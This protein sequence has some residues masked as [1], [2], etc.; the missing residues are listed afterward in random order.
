MASHH[1]KPFFMYKNRQKVNR[2]FDGKFTMSR[3]IPG[4]S[5]RPAELLKRHLAGTVPP[6]DL[7]NRY[8]YHFNE[9]GEQ[10]AL[11]LPLELHEVH[12][13][14]VA[15]R[16]KQYEEAL[17]HRKAM[18]EKHKQEIIAAYKLEQEKSKVEVEKKDAPTPPKGEKPLK[19][20]TPKG[21]RDR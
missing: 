1:F 2:E 21:G 16:K 14:S 6:I 8:E 9:E 17:E 19:S 18:A 20:P 3:T 11:P 13:L 7:S 12:R 10:V 4:Q 5:L 15:I